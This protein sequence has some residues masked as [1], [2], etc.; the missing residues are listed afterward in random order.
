MSNQSMQTI[1]PW[2]SVI[3]H[4]NL[5]P[6]FDVNGLQEEAF[7]L[8]QMATDEDEKQRYLDPDLFKLIMGTRD[9][10]ITP[11]VTAYA[12]NLWDYDITGRFEVETNAK[13]IPE[14]E[15]LFPHYHPG[16][17]ISV[18]VYPQDSKSGLNIFDPR[19]HACRGYPKEIRDKHFAAYKISPKA[20]DVYIFPSYMQHSVSYVQE[21]VRMSIL[22]EYYLRK[23]V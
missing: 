19:V 16:S 13:W 22:H 9:S 8:N 14:G 4:F 7:T 15:G 11:A 23:N 6:M 20:G 12:K 2:R 3:G 10:V 1:E 21:D 17:C 5:G 18:I